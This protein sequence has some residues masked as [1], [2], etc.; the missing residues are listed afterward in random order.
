MPHDPSRG[1]R[2]ASAASARETYASSRLLVAVLSGALGLAAVQLH[3]SFVPADPFESQQ[4]LYFAGGASGLWAGWAVMA[5]GF[6]RGLRAQVFGAIS[7]VF[8]AALALSL[9]GGVGSVLNTYSFGA[10]GT[11]DELLHHLLAKSVATGTAIA[12]S[13]ALFPAA[14]AALATALLGDLAHRLWD[15]PRIEP[16][17]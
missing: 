1:P 10:F 5:R 4:G 17:H 8:A 6:G 7:A 2:A 11:V 13:P 14:L 9:A 3:L 16:I 12:G 15:E